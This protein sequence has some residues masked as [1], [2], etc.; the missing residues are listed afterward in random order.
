MIVEIEQACPSCRP[1]LDYN[2]GKVL[3][4]VAELIAYA[5]MESTDSKYIYELFDR[6]EKTRYYIAEK[7]FHASVNP[8]E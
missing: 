4:G 7:S 2:E 3:R 1:S 6:Y 8:S 5:N